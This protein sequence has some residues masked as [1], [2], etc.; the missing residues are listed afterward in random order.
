MPS[1]NDEPQL[2]LPLPL[3][4]RQ[5]SRLAPALLLLGLIG[6]GVYAA[7]D[8]DTQAHRENSFAA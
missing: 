4:A 1:A 3:P 7:S 5:A 6:G 8:A 2:E